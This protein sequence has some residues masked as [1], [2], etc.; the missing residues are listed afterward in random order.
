LIETVV[1]IGFV[2]TETAIKLKR[3]GALERLNFWET[4]GLLWQPWKCMFRGVN[5]SPKSKIKMYK[6]IVF[7]ILISKNNLDWYKKSAT[8]VGV[9]KVS[10]PYEKWR[11]KGGNYGF[12]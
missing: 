2:W 7:V 1:K 3:N 9:R 12:P 11:G 4:L 10:Q 6:V 8:W 5:T